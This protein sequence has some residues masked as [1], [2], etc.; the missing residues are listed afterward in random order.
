MCGLY[1]RHPLWNLT[2]ITSYADNKPQ[3]TL[4]IICVQIIFQKTIIVCDIFA[5]RQQLTGTSGVD[6]FLYTHTQTHTQH[7]HKHLFIAR[8]SL[9][10]QYNIYCHQYKHF[11]H[12]LK[13]YM[14]PD[15]FLIKFRCF[16]IQFFNY[17]NCF[18]NRKIFI[19]F[20]NFIMNG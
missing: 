15:M 20:L 13:F 19:Y 11:G 14:N 12:K 7:N 17:L 4:C 6:A 1:I 3:S 9:I 10:E 18:I 16:K 2:S 8:F 5:I